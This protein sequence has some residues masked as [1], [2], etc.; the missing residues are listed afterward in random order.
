MRAL[1]DASGG[2]F[3]AATTAAD[4]ALRCTGVDDFSAMLAATVKTI[5]VGELGRADDLASTVAFART[6]G[7]ASPSTGL[8]RFALAEA[9]S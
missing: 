4:A 1:L 9:H 3:V 7:A 2:D 5:A 8:L 6:L